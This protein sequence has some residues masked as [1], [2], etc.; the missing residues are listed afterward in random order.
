MFGSKATVDLTITSD[1]ATLA[2]TI[3]ILY[4]HLK[5]EFNVSFVRLFCQKIVVK[6]L[7]RKKNHDLK[8]KLICIFIATKI[9][10]LKRLK[11]IHLSDH[12]ET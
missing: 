12:F 8:A 1:R 3:S 10:S 4:K 6:H 5:I 2:I 9:S 7:Y 11:L